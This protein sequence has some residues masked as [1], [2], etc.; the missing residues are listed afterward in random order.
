MAELPGLRGVY[1]ALIEQWF[2]ADAARV[3]PN[4]AQFQ[5]LR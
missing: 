1:A 2:G 5:L 3:I 4:A